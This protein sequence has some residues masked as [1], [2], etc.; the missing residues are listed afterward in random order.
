MYIQLLVFRS[1]E[2]AMACAGSIGQ[3]AFLD[4]QSATPAIRSIAPETP[5]VN[6]LYFDNAINQG[7]VPTIPARVAPAPIV[8]NSAGSAQHTSVPADV[9]RLSEGRSVCLIP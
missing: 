7:A 4:R 6:V 8:T 1:L 3:G 5:N 2:H 9:N